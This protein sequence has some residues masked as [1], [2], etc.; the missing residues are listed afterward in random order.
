MRAIRV[1]M[2]FNSIGWIA[3]AGDCDSTPTPAENRWSV[4]IQAT[5]IGQAHGAFR[6]L[7]E[8]DNSLPA[9]LER[10]V[11]LT[12]TAFITLRLAA[13]WEL[14]L[15]PEIAGG[16]GFGGVTGIAGFTNGEIPRVSQARPT[17]YLAR[18]YLKTTIPLGTETEAVESGP[19]QRAGSVPVRRMTF[20]NGKFAITDYMDGNSYSHD[21]RTQFMNWSMMYA[22]AWDYPADTRGYT[23]GTLEEIRMPKWSLRAAMVMEPTSAN[24]PTFDTR[25][26]RN[27]G[28]ALEFER[29]YAIAGRKGAVRL[30]GFENRENAGT[31]REGISLDSS[32]RNGTL[33]YGFGVN[34][35]QALSDDV[36]VFGRYSWN[37]GK[38][39][40]WAFTEIDRSLSG[41]VSIRGNRWHRA[42]DTIGAGMVRNQLSGDH[43]SFLAAGGYGFIIGDGRL[44]YSPEKVVEVY[45]AFHVGRGWTVT[46]DYQHVN[47]PAYNRDRG[48]VSVGTIRIHFEM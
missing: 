13:N 37:D 39:E 48:P 42:Q 1:F 22:G 6:S 18:G 36:G 34:L 8:G 31:Y 32:R 38:T 3:F 12:S 14:V 16:Q 45:Y 46:G 7:Y 4:H 23:I 40:T 19:N 47:N 35:E 21:P 30:L 29:D 27:R 28:A 44:N 17:L 41:G 33:K 10:R 43:R 5:S 25:M 26:G 24:G 11:S 2:F 15:N 20:I 9:H